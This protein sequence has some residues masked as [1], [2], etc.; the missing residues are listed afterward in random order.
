[1]NNAI[2]F[3]YI[4]RNWELRDGIVYSKRTGKPVSFSVKDKYGRRFTVIEINRKRHA[5]RVYEAIF[6]LFHDRPIAEGKELH[7]K[8]GNHQNNDIENLIELTDKQHRRIHKFQCDDPLRGIYLEGGAWRFFWYDDNGRFRGRRFHS[9]NDAMAFR[10]EIERPR[11]Q[12]LRALGLNCKHVG[13]GEKPRRLYAA[14]SYFSRSNAI[15]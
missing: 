3:E 1:M 10:A 7:H 6:M 5:V 15:L 14:R 13:S 12:E 8:D 4:K 9:I 11:R 2:K